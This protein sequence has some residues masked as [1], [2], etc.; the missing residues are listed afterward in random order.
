MKRKQSLLVFEQHVFEQHVFGQHVFGQ[1]LRKAVGE[2]NEGTLANRGSGS[3]W[4]RFCQGN[5]EK[6]C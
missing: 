6:G 3:F 4:G 2:G 1:D 5:E